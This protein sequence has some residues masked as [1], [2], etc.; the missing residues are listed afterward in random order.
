M[1]NFQGMDSMMLISGYD[2][3]KNRSDIS[4]SRDRLAIC[5][6][7]EY[8]NFIL[9]RKYIS[10]YE[11]K[12]LMNKDKITNEDL[13]KTVD[14][15]L[16]GGTYLPLEDNFQLTK[17]M[18]TETVKE[19]NYY[20]ENN[21]MKRI[22]YVPR[23]SS[24]IYYVH[25]VNSTYGKRISVC[26]LFVA[27]SFEAWLLFNSMQLLPSLYHI[28]DS[29]ILD[30][31]QWNGWALSFLHHR[32][33]RYKH[34]SL[35]SRG[36]NPFP[37]TNVDANKM[38]EIL[39]F[40]TISCKELFEN[41]EQVIVIDNISTIS[42]EDDSRQII[43][44]EYNA[45]NTTSLKIL[46]NIQN[47]YRLQLIGVKEENLKNSTLY[48]RHDNPFV[49]YWK[50]AKN[51]ISKVK[52]T[53]NNLYEMLEK[54]WSVLVYVKNVRTHSS[55]IRDQML[56]I[57]N[58]QNKIKC[59]THKYLLIT[60][61]SDSDTC[62]Y[63]HRKSKLTCP[64]K[65]CYVCICEKCRN[66]LLIEKANEEYITI[67]SPTQS[68]E[69]IDTS[70]RGKSIDLDVDSITGTENIKL[71]SSG[72]TYENEDNKSLLNENLLDEEESSQDGQNRD[73]ED[74]LPRTWEADDEDDGLL[75]IMELGEQDTEEIDEG[76]PIANAGKPIVQFRIMAQKGELISDHALLNTCGHLLQR[77]NKRLVQTRAQKNFL[78]RL[79]STQKGRYVPLLYPE[80]EIFPNL[81]WHSNEDGSIPGAIP[82]CF[83]QDN[84]TL[85]NM[86]I[87]SLLQHIRTRILD[88]SLLSSSSHKY[89]GFAW[90]MVANL[91]LRGYN[92][93]LILRRGFDDIIGT[94]E[95][96]RLRTPDLHDTHS[97]DSR[98]TV[99]QLAAANGKHRCDLFFTWTCDQKDTLCVNDIWS[100]CESDEAVKLICNKYNTQQDSIFNYDETQEIKMGLRQSA[101][102]YML[103]SWI[104]IGDEFLDYLKRGKDSPFINI[105]GGIEN[106]WDRKEIQGNQQDGK[107][108]HHHTLFFFK[109]TIPSEEERL[110][111]LDTIRGCMNSCCTT[112][113]RSELIEKGF[114]KDVDMLQS[115]L[116]N[117]AIKLK[118]HCTTR[119]LIPVRNTEGIEPTMER[120][121]K[122][123]D[124]RIINPTP[125]EHYMKKVNI[126]HSQ[127]TLQ[128][129][130]LLDMIQDCRTKE[131]DLLECIPT[132]ETKDF[133]S[134][135]KHCPPCYATDGP[136]SPANIFL[137]AMLCSTMNLQYCTAY[138]VVRYLTKYVASIDKAN[139]LIIKANPEEEND[140]T[141]TITDK[142]NTKITSNRIAQQREQIKH[143]KE[144]FEIT[145]RNLSVT[146]MLMQILLYKPVSTS[147]TFEYIPT[148]PMGMRPMLK[149]KS[150]AQRI[151]Q[152][153]TSTHRDLDASDLFSG[154]IIRKKEYNNVLRQYD[155][156]QQVT[157]LDAI[158][159][160]GSIDKVTIFSLRPPELLFVRKLSWYF[161]LFC[162]E[163]YMTT[164]QNNPK[165]NIEKLQK[166]IQPEYEKCEWIDAMGYRLKIRAKAVPI[167]VEHL[168]TKQKNYPMEYELLRK[169][170]LYL[171]PTFTMT[172]SHI[173]Y[174]NDLAERFLLEGTKRHETKIPIPWYRTIKSTQGH[175]FLYHL[176]LSLGEFT[177]E[178]ELLAQGS[179]LRSF[180]FA[181]LFTT[182]SDPKDREESA[183]DIIRHY[184][185]TQ[186]SHYPCG[187]VL[188]D[189]QVNTAF[190]LIRSFLL[191]NNP[192][193]HS[194]PPVLYT[195]LKESATIEHENYYNSCQRS[196]IE[197][198]LYFANNMYQPEAY[199][200]PAAD[201]F[202]NCS[203]DN[204]MLD[205]SLLSLPKLRNQSLESFKEHQN[206]FKKIIK[207]VTEYKRGQ[208]TI[209][210]SLVLVGAGG[211]GK[212][213]DMRLGALYM[214]SQGL[215]VYSTCLMGK[216]S[217][218]L[219]GRHLAIFLKYPTQQGLSPAEIAEK[220]IYALMKDPKSIALI[221]VLNAICLD[222]LSQ[223]SA[224]F[225]SVLHMVLCRIRGNNLPFGGI[226]MIFTLDHLQ[227]E[228]IDG[229]FCLFNPK[230]M[231]SMVYHRYYV[232]LRTTCKVLLR[233]QEISRMDINQLQKLSIKNEFCDLIKNHCNFVANIDDPSIPAEAIFCFSK[234]TLCRHAE[235]TIL[236]K[237][238]TNYKDK[239]IEKR[240]NDWQETKLQHNPSPATQSVS[241]M[242]DNKQKTPQSLLLY[243]FA[244]YE[245]TFND[246][247]ENFFQSQICILLDVPN[248]TELNDFKPI[249]LFRAPH[250]T[251]EIPPLP[252]NETILLSLGWTKI[253][254]V[255]QPHRIINLGL[256][257]L[258]GWRIQY[259]L[260]PKISSTIHSLMGSTTS[261][262]VTQVGSTND[263]SLWEAG[264][265]VVLLSRTRTA[266]D[267]YFIGNSYDTANALYGALL[268]RKQHTQYISL[269][270]DK[271]CNNESNITLDL[272][273]LNFPYRM[274]DCAL[275]SIGIP[276]AYMLV[277][278]THTE[279][280]YVGSTTNI[281]QRLN[282][283]NSLH[284]GSQWTKTINYK[285][286]GLMG[287][288][289]GFNSQREARQ[290]E[291]LWQHK[292]QDEQHSNRY[293]LNANA[294]LRLATKIFEE[295]DGTFTNLKLQVIGHI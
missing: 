186:L 268:R 226:I 41:I 222:E 16:L 62:L 257:G 35:H 50:Y 261:K 199:I 163:P 52:T 162:R 174:Y 223:L 55:N 210:N 9:D 200:L 59:G 161:T 189:T 172:R 130:L 118:H 245:I 119:C 8:R 57:Q 104:A 138:I 48:I 283:H 193:L 79:I 64:F 101:H 274:K 195:Q 116:E 182:S 155:M 42:K 74:D 115:L 181:R 157:Y 24:R 33:L 236:N 134:A 159:T 201:S 4:Y 20:D 29:N 290:F 262:L 47:K 178:F 214:I 227:L 244:I 160:P 122:Q 54:S 114:V 280:T 90:D 142:Y 253:K 260:R 126:E 224:G 12:D 1:G 207:I 31:L 93:E 282:N 240:S 85:N 286:W 248:K 238:K 218:E 80:A 99:N 197:N 294:K 43:I 235:E 258:R 239:Y 145:A 49:N 105:V 264:Q 180:Q 133:L 86:G 83:L 38:L 11:L 158:N 151:I 284:G 170:Q 150:I 56:C 187:T 164:L 88:P 183:N 190:E 167:L 276:L 75:N 213:M 109:T 237:F 149:S 6:R 67:S 76:L 95:D 247:D 69:L 87:A 140:M 125:T 191:D 291:T 2:I 259:G 30:N 123:V 241:N 124:Y 221:K 166:A 292:I 176:L 143:H 293:Q 106:I 98:A 40:P 217:A 45:E 77:R 288:V 58:G 249:I 28:V 255:K 92:A 25:P 281:K 103:L 211:V 94:N 147:F 13:T 68:K 128:I 136:Y 168:K 7:A 82:L 129:L 153:S 15:C 192:H 22:S 275:P 267:L 131:S 17:Q 212:T 70:N 117:Y 184:I 229:Q 228:S 37:I 5:N 203:M 53:P 171:Q 273:E 205:F 97:I 185:K 242:L 107:L 36:F 23:W 60:A 251:D 173:E 27:K 10:K 39:N 46:D 14:K 110:K 19:I 263:D 120:R 230:M 220:C 231:T 225:L 73:Y 234:H 139:K 100:W 289:T 252:T 146:E 194:T 254:M 278:Q 84:K 3:S 127:R 287:V 32:F 269:L 165:D 175:I 250:G 144:N 206:A 61:L 18:S 152:R 91:G 135:E 169:L 272:K 51:N 102:I 108:P 196:I 71:S 277:S 112:K 34:K 81:F 295:H 113:E 216:R 65:T 141:V 208:L 44:R 246:K 233:I 188:F 72:V 21:R 285:P 121:C 266:R 271:L 256:N 270:L 78:Q 111:M 204:P 96:I 89:F 209:T 198:V 232:P 154:Y 26:S 66:R 137:F 202:L 132:D 265:V 279:I 215:R 243:P 156:Y 148:L 219:G 179:L 63:C 177:S